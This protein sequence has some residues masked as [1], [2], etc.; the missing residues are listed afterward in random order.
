MPAAG[1]ELLREP[2]HGCCMKIGRILVGV[3]AL[4]AVVLAFVL[5]QKNQTEL[6]RELA[7]L[8]NEVKQAVRQAGGPAMAAELPM[9]LIERQ[10][11]ERD[12]LTMLREDIGNL[13]VNTQELLKIARTTAPR[14][15][16]NTVPAGT[17]TDL[18]PAHALRNA[19]RATPEAAAETLLWAAFGGDVE[20]L[21]EGLILPAAARAKADAWFA[22]LPEST[23]AQ[24]GSPEKVIALLIARGADTL[25][26]MQI[27]G[28]REVAPDEVGVRMRFADTQGNTKED[29]FL[30]HRAVDGWRL[31]LPEAAVERFA[32]QVAGRK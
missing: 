15:A 31:M 13:R 5:Q 18:I 23:R 16:V 3:A 6:R 8:R 17:G 26:A 29:N 27:I 9:A 2:C 22:S 11:G 30:L 28:Q 24:Y 20:T 7:L 21:A 14:T 25:G 1:I 32:R 19:G 12:V 10:D 4:V